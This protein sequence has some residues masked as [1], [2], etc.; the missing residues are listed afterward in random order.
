MVENFKTTEEGY[1][2]YKCFDGQYTHPKSWK[3]E[4]GSYIEEEVNSCRADICGC[5]INFATE[6]WV[7]DNYKNPV[8]ECL[9]EWRDAC[10]IVVPY[11]TGG[12]ARCGRIKLLKIVKP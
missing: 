6:E 9:I 2:V 1:I 3:I 4:K 11:N 10:T 5:G 12:K 7:R 8:W